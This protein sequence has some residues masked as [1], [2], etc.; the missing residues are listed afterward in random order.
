MVSPSGG[1][2][3]ALSYFTNYN[4]WKQ[5]GGQVVIGNGTYDELLPQSTI[6][7]YII[8]GAY[9]TSKEFLANIRPLVDQIGLMITNQQHYAW[10]VAN[11]DAFGFATQDEGFVEYD[12]N[13][14]A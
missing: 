2:Y 12:I 5:K 11:L 6:Q 8:Q 1:S 9:S 10:P 4:W 13:R 14:H 3:D 7:P